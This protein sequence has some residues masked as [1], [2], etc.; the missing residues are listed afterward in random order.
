[1]SNDFDEYQKAALRTAVYPDIGDN[2][3]YPALGL[4][5][6]AGEL[7][8]KV[9]KII[10]DDGRELTEKRIAEIRQELVDI[11]WYAA[12]VAFEIGESLSTIAHQNIRKLSIRAAKGK[13]HGE[14]DER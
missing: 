11:V 13:V 8:N 9:K 12:L 7:A 14:G 6:E 1:M 5:G 3:I 4:T 2:I 10:R